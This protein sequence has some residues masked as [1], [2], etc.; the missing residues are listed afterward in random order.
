MSDRVANLISALKDEEIPSQLTARHHGGGNPGP[1]SNVTRIGLP[2]Y[3]WCAI[4]TPALKSEST[5]NPQS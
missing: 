5:S 3:D 2:N 1:N 4:H